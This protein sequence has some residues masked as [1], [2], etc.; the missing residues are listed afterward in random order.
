MPPGY[1]LWPPP[2]EHQVAAPPTA[3]CRQELHAAYLAVTQ[4]FWQYGGPYIFGDWVEIYPV[5]P[6]S[7][8]GA[9]DLPFQV[10][11]HLNDLVNSESVVTLNLVIMVWSLGIRL[12]SVL[13]AG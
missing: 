7:L 1:G 10:V 5:P 13:A 9:E 3:S 11:L 6:P 2:G 12:M 8:H 4:P